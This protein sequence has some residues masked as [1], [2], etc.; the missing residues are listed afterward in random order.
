MF[1]EGAA[2]FHSL[3]IKANKRF[4]NHLRFLLAYTFGK[5]IDNGPAP[6]NL[7]H[8]QN[9]H[10]QPQ[11]PY[12]LSLERAIADNDIKHNLVAS[13]SY[14][15][16]FARGQR[17]LPNAGGLTQGIL[18]GWQI[19]GIFAAR[20]G[21]PVNV[22]RNA[23]DLGYQ[24]LRPD[25][26]R[27]PNL[28]RSNRT[29]TRYFDLGAFSKSRFTGSHGHDLGTAGRNLVRGPGF[30]NLDFSIL[31]DIRIEERAT[32]QLRFEFFNLPNTPHFANPNGNM[33]AGNFGSITQ[34]IGNPRII[35][36]GAKIKF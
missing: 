10:N 16:P 12:N 11:D 24:G 26:L 21:L 6:F 18:G 14:E 32:L 7:G 35:Q 17:F 15:L 33:L 1:S 30:V 4:S 27:D 19:N 22:V 20:S 36:F 34:T 13:Y 29:L 23:Q 5:S 28:P 25:I 31:R 3:Q 8:N 2:D 9:S